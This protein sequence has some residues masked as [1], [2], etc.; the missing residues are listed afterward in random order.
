MGFSLLLPHLRRMTLRTTQ[1]AS[2]AWFQPP[3]SPPCSCL[4]LH[5]QGLSLAVKS[6]WLCAG[7]LGAGGGVAAGGG[8][9]VPREL[10]RVSG[11]A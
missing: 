7:R 8:C 6:Q 5:P 11:Q 4:P 1:A 2:A 9:P 3:C 10:S